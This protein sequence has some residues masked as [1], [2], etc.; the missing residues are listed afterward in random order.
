[1]SSPFQ[2]HISWN[3][4]NFPQFETL[5]IS[6]KKISEVCEKLQ[7]NKAKGNDM[8]PPIL[9]R[10]LKDHLAHSL[11]QLFS[12]A[13]QTCVYPSEWKKAVVIPLF[14]G[15]SKQIV[16]SYRPVSLLTIP[17]KIFEKLLF[18]RLY[19]H[20]KPLLHHSQYGFRPRRSTVTHLLVML[21]KIYSALEND[22]EI[23]VVFTDFSK[24][25]DKVDHGILLQK[26]SKYGIGGKLLKLIHSYPN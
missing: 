20:L 13:L 14:K 15:G 5:V 24:A 17:S 16:A 7:L 21:D 10:K 2:E 22:Y 18:K 26:L 11:H 3:T 9:F 25:F 12:K 1:M 6:V 8:L 4:P 23:N 19:L